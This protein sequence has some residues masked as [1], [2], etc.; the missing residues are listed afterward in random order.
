M[1]LFCGENA[2]NV[3]YLTLSSFVFVHLFLSCS[4]VA[5][6]VPKRHSRQGESGQTEQLAQK[7]VFDWL[8]IHFA[9]R[10]RSREVFLLEVAQTD[11][12][13]TKGLQY[14]KVGP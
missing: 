2:R 6:L 11:V 3:S 12:C 5:L 8:W 1:R 9:R 13:S 7:M 14:G 4:Q 10:V